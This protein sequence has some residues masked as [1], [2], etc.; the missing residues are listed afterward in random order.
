[1]SERSAES[2]SLA[3]LRWRCRRGMRELDEL[4]QR[5][6]EQRYPYAREIERR[7]F[8]SLVELPDPTLLAYLLNQQT[9]TDPDLQHVIT[10]I[11]ET[12]P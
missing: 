6:L 4:L 8:E 9:P 5:Y 7:V 12:G 2:I 10:R 11:T 1:M 3:R